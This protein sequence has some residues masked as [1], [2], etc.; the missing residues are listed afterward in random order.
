MDTSPLDASLWLDLRDV[1]AG[2]RAEAWREW[3]R[4]CFPEYSILSSMDS[5]G[6]VLRSSRSA[7]PACGWSASLPA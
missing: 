3:M 5:G 6:G 7:L 1:A 4:T 2:R